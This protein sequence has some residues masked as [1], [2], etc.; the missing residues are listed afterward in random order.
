MFFFLS[1]SLA[2]FLTF[3]FSFFL[4]LSL[5]YIKIEKTFS[6]SL[7]DRRKERSYFFV[8]FHSIK[9]DDF[10]R[11]TFPFPSSLSLSL[12]ISSPSVRKN[13]VKGRERKT[14]RKMERMRCVFRDERH[15]TFLFL[16][17]LH[18]FFLSSFFHLS[19]LSFLSLSFFLSPSVTPFALTISTLF[20]PVRYF[21]LP[22][23]FFSSISFFLFFLL[24]SSSYQLFTHYSSSFRVSPDFSSFSLSHSSFFFSSFVIVFFFFLSF[25]SLPLSPSSRYINSVFLP[26]RKRRKKSQM[27]EKT[28]E[29]LFLSHENE[30]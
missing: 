5:C 22:I 12:F 3:L 15:A 8:F 16:T 28:N 23:F 25:L 18:L 13:G 27:S 11:V 26:K 24:F 14:G 7:E 9:Q 29:K 20:L 19:L 10:S 4:S 2:F 17:F 6:H 30:T 21:F 1:L